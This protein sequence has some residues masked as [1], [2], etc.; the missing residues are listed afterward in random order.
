MSTVAVGPRFDER[1]MRI[2]SDGS[3]GFGDF[4][5]HLPKVHAIHHRRGNVVAFRAIDDLLE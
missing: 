5:A 2:L 4:V 3:N 1:W